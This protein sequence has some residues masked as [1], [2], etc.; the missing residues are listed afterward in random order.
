MRTTGA[1]V[2]FLTLIALLG[3]QQRSGPLQLPASQKLSREERRPD[4]LARNKEAQALF[5]ASRYR[6]AGELF[7]AAYRDALASGESEWAGALLANAGSVRFALYNYRGALDAY[8]EARELSRQAGD[9]KTV[10]A[11]SANVSSLYWAM[12]DDAAA[13]EAAESGL[14]ILSRPEGKPY[15]SQLLIHLAKLRST[16]GRQAEALALFREGMDGALAEGDLNSVAKAWDRIGDEFLRQGRLDE[17]ERAMLE[18]FRLRKLNRVPNLDLSY[19]AL[20]MLRF[21]QGDLASSST[22]LDEAVRR[23]SSPLS[24]LYHRYHRGL[25]REAQGRIEE[26]LVDYR[27]A[28]H[29]ARRRRL[30]ALPA[31][32]TRVSVEVGLQDIYSALVEAQNREALAAGNPAG[33]RET[34]ELAQENRAASLRALLF[35]AG[36]WRRRLPADYWEVLGRLEAAEARMLR[37]PSESSM[38]EIRRLEHSLTEMEAG[39]GSEFTADSGGMLKR[40]QKRLGREEA[41]LSF[42]LGKSESWLWAVTDSR[43]ALY[44]LPTASE[45]V[46]DVLRF[47]E[48]LAADEPL[49]A[50]LGR[51]LYGN[52]FGPLA[53]HFQA[54]QRWYLSPDERLFDLPF[55]ALR[56]EAG[57]YLVETHSIGLTPSGF[58]VPR[59]PAAAGPFVGIGDPVY[60]HADP[61]WIA[62]FSG[63]EACPSDLHL[64]RLV[65]S[66]REIRSCA[67]AWR[68][69]APGAIL[70]EGFAAGKRGLE[71]ALASRPAVIH[72]ATHFIRNR[73]RP[74]RA[75]IALTLA[76]PDSGMEELGFLGPRE[77]A[78]WNLDSPLVVLSGCSSG[79]AEALPG[80]GLMGMTRAWL[81]A[82]A[83]SVVASHWST[84]D[85]SGGLFLSF[86]KHL[87]DG[88]RSDPAAALSRAQRE[89]LR[90][91]NWRAR[92]AYWS[93]F[94]VLGSA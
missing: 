46:G 23:A 94:F 75:F 85:D 54:K 51:S 48:A 42:H 33:A 34:F 16:E 68:P 90:S 83:S 2:W 70:L 84:P 29:Q 32:G 40:L 35:D 3:A 7:E 58:L 43:F 50:T 77:I 57:Q 20:G 5:H 71:G 4:L 66:G 28:V 89:M 64:S 44:R 91:G 61:R 12:E 59:R 10:G 88:D 9:M 53:A 24:L 41:F 45:L 73:H 93:A 60:N 62:E 72:F 74:N 1:T 47:R 78:S 63:G 11:L 87:R 38:R 30:T 6:E 65:A 13:L 81:A 15:R 80:A 26:A 25:T 19:R 69:G 49:A 37:T 86:Y 67:Q 79:R 82:G 56:N 31:D 92:P 18:A 8:R 27:A 17:A 22:L 14:R 76:R 52:L 36:A 39:T 21:A 55:G